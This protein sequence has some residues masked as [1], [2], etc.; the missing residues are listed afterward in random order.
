TAPVVEA[1]VVPEPPPPPPPP[2]NQFR[3]FV[4]NLKISGVR[5]GATPRV[6]I[7]G[8][9]F[10][11]GDLVNPQLGITFEGYSSA[12]RLLTFKDQTGAKVERRH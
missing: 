9:S 6:F 4:E 12:T 8:T 7:G 1:P 11:K 10:Q 3:A 5:G 2:S